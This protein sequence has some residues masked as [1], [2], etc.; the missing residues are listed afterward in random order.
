MITL[1]VKRKNLS[2][3]IRKQTEIARDPGEINAVKVKQMF[4]KATYDHPRRIL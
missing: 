3:I 1:R 4:P 2:E